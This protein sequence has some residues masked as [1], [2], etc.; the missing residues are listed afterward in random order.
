[1][2][3]HL[4]AVPALDGEKISSSACIACWCARKIRNN[5]LHV[6]FNWEGGLGRS[7]LSVSTKINASGIMHQLWDAWENS[8][9]SV[10][11]YLETSQVFNEYVYSPMKAAHIRRDIKVYKTDR[12]QNYKQKIKKKRKLHRTN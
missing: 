11:S 4:D 5:L 3:I 8:V 9:I 2:Y 10:T 1:M 6:E 7:P 12:G